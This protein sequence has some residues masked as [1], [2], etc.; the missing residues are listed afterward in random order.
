MRL[1]LLLALALLGRTAVAASPAEIER[2]VARA[3]G[4]RDT[5]RAERQQVQA[6]AA[7]AAERVAALKRPGGGTD[8]A[9]SA[10]ARELREFD[11]LAARLDTLEREVATFEQRLARLRAAFEAAADDEEGRLEERARREGA[12]AVA[13]QIEALRAARRRIAG[14]AETPGFRP[15]LDIGLSALDGV[16]ELEAKLALIDGERARIT[17]RL[18]EARREETL[19]ATRMEAKREWARQLAAA[20]RD[21]AGSVDLLDRGYE[22]AQSALRGLAARIEALARERSTLEEAEQRLR[23]RRTEAEGRLAELRKGR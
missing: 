11:R 2:D 18:V 13:P 23:A 16:A 9:G 14:Q 6:Q 15:P 19:L 4:E 7:A 10:L 21:A 22:E 20:R 8:R 17:Q 3:A 12:A 5:R 1:G